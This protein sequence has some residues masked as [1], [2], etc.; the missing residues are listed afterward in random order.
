MNNI[1]SIVALL[2]FVLYANTAASYSLQQ[3]YY[4]FVNATVS[5][6]SQLVVGVNTTNFVNLVVIPQSQYQNY[7]SGY[8]VSAVYNKSAGSGIYLLN[9]SAGTYTVILSAAYGA[10]NISYGTLVVPKNKGK[11]IFVNP[12]YRLPLSLSNYS[13][14]NVTLMAVSPTNVSVFIYH[15]QF[16][17][18]GG[19]TWWRVHLDRG[20]YN[21]T[22][23]NKGSTPAF[24]LVNVTPQL[25]DPLAFANKSTN[26]PMGIASYGIYNA[27][28]RQIP[29]QIKTDLVEGTATIT[30]IHAYNATPTPKASKDGA[31]LQLNVMMRVLSGS[32]TYVYWLQNV[33]S[34]T[35]SNKYVKLVDNI[36]NNTII[37]AN[38]SKSLLSGRGSVAVSTQNSIPDH[39]KNQTY[40]GYTTSEFN[41]NATFVFTPIIKVW[42]RQ[43][44]PV[45]SFAYYGKNSTAYYDNVTLSIPAD[46]AYLLVTPYY[47]TPG[48][49]N[50]SGVWYDSELVFGGQTNYELTTFTD[51]NATL[52]MYYNDRGTMRPF[53]SLYTFGKDTAE[54]ATNLNVTPTKGGA[55]VRVG[56]RAFGQVITLSSSY[57]NLV[58]TPPPTQ[59]QPPTTIFVPPANYNMPTSIDFNAG[60]GLLTIVVGG[61]MLLTLFVIVIYIP[62]RAVLFIYRH[63][64]PKSAASA[65]PAGPKGKK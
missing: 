50:S 64:R 4:D 30:S 58:T 37:G 14:V 5:P 47:L 11:V 62:Y 63:I 31:S 61:L 24:L 48:N 8:R 21:I 10:V 3:Y 52:W 16:N 27:S 45:V 25:T 53:P 34:F 33:A 15:T 17:T 49:S 20:N 59:G 18:S 46:D 44:F 43:G 41:Y 32:K 42:L 38:V 54:A 2:V 40:Y 51:L 23:L 13:L 12:T 60:P 56:N 28:G 29:Y 36:W 39:P 35:T 7:Q 9:L 57:Q 1:K 19:Y 6:N 65:K 26:T 55:L 22:L